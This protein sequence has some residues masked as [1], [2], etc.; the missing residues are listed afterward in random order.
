MRP[1]HLLLVQLFET[2]KN[3]LE[4]VGWEDGLAVCVGKTEKL[5]E[6]TN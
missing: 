1:H 5:L 2:E 3:Q 4:L 6:L